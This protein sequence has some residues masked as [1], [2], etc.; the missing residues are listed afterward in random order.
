MAQI[1]E[2]GLFRRVLPERNAGSR[3]AP[4]AE[5]R[6]KQAKTAPDYHQIER[7]VFTQ[8]WIAVV[9]YWRAGHVR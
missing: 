9:H 2:K 6:E 8:S 3:T 4:E 5:T 1:G 7:S